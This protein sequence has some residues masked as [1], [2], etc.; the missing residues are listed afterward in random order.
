MIRKNPYIN[1]GEVLKLDKRSS[2]IIKK[3]KRY[4]V[5]VY[6]NL[7][8]GKSLLDVNQVPNGSHGKIATDLF[9]WILKS[10]KNRQMSKD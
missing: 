10:E 4:G 8:I 3:A 7:A 2:I 5:V 9:M 1:Q 6:D